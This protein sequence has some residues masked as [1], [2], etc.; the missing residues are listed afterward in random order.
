MEPTFGI[1]CQMIW[2]Y[3]VKGLTVSKKWSRNGK[4]SK[5]QWSL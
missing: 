5:C 2:G 4:G 1:F 3:V